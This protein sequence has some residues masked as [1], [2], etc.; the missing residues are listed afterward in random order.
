MTFRIPVIRAM[1]RE[2]R[3][4]AWIAK[5]VKPA[6]AHAGP[7]ELHQLADTTLTSLTDTAQQGVQQTR[8][9]AG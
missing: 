3:M 5:H 8:R 7:A 6:T 9:R 2:D 4:R 1:T